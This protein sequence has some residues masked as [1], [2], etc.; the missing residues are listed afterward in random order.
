MLDKIIQAK[1]IILDKQKQSLPLEVIQEKL[2]PKV[3]EKSGFKEALKKEGL[4]IIGEIKKASPSQGTMNES[5]DIIET[6]RLYES[7]GVASISVLTE[8]KYFKGSSE[9]LQKV[10]EAVSIPTLRK[11]FIIDSYQIYEAKLLGAHAVLLIAAILSIE[12]LENFYCLSKSLGMDC[13]VEVHNEEDIEKIK[14]IQPDIVGINNRNLATLEIDLQTTERLLPFLKE[15]EIVVSES[16]IMSQLELDYIKELGVDAVLMGRFFMDSSFVEEQL[17][18]L[19]LLS[20]KVKICGLKTIHDIEIVN[21]YRPDYIGVVFAQSKRKVTK[22]LA[23]KMIF[24]LS[25]DIKAVG[26]FTDHSIEE[27]NA[28]ATYCGL[29]VIQFHRSVSHEEYKKSTKELWM[30]LPVSEEGKYQEVPLVGDG[31]LLDTKIGSNCGGLGKSFDWTKICC[32]QIGKKT[33]VAGGLQ[34]SNVGQC[35]E[36]L[37]PYCVDVS[38]GVEEKG[39]KSKRLIEAFIKSVRGGCGYE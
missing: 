15:T 3:F 14:G 8:E 4:S 1:Q 36:L 7:Y 39:N 24:K 27:A 23:R 37:R 17:K 22:E 6:A 10:S 29:D 34:P 12:D 18:T 30:T 38:S 13:L 5:L 19:R 20:T 2:T 31:V 21:E 26:V 11:D 32:K 16:G 9:Y 28:L 35:I 33:I 25:R